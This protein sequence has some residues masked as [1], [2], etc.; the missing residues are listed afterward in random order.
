MSVGKRKF[1]RAELIRAL[2]QAEGI[3]ADAARLLGV[4]R[5]TVCRRVQ[6]DPGLRDLI[7]EIV[8]ETLDAAESAIRKA[9]REGDLATSRWFL[10]RKAK[11]RGYGASM[12]VRLSDR[13]IQEL[14]EE[15]ARDHPDTLKLL[16]ER[17]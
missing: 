13:D 17:G 12:S 15:L 11:L 9:I 3:Q 4:E 1:S 5:S 8:E 2:R 14:V 10:D 16:A 6:R 7:E